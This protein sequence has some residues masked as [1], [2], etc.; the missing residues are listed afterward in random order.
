MFSRRIGH[1]RL[2]LAL[3]PLMIT[4]ALVIPATPLVWAQTSPSPC[5][6]VDQI[7][8][9]HGSVS[10]SHSDAKSWNGKSSD[11]YTIDEWEAADSTSVSGSGAVTQDRQYGYL[12]NGYMNGANTGAYA[13]SHK[14][15][16]TYPGYPPIIAYPS[17]Q[18]WTAQGGSSRVFTQIYVFAS[19]CTAQ[20]IIGANIEGTYDSGGQ[21]FASAEANL[22]K[23]PI[24]RVGNRF[25]I[26]GVA[27]AL[28]I[29]SGS[30]PIGEIPPHDH[31]VRGVADYVGMYYQRE[32]RTR[33]TARVPITYSFHSDTFGPAPGQLSIE[34]LKLEHGDYPSGNWITV[35][36]TGTYDGNI[37]RATIRLRNPGDQPVEAILDV[38]ETVANVRI[39]TCP[40][41]ITVPPTGNG[42]LREIS[43]IWDTQGF[44]WSDGA[45]PQASSNRVIRATLT[46][47]GG[48]V[49]TREAPVIVNPRPVFLFHNVN[50]NAQ[51][52][53]SYRGFMQ[54]RHQRWPLFTI[55]EMAT[56][57]SWNNPAQT[58]S[59]QQN[60]QIAN[61][62]IERRR[63]DLDAWHFD[64]LGHG[65]GGLVA[66]YYLH[67][68]APA[69]PERP[70]VRNLIM[71]GAPNQGTECALPHVLIDLDQGSINQAMLE[72]T[73]LLMR[74]F[75]A[76]VNNTK[77]AQLSVLLGDGPP[78]D[79]L[80]ADD[81]EFNPAPLVGSDGWVDSVSAAGSF[82]DVS[83]DTE[84]RHFRMLENQ[85]PFLNA[86]FPRL[87]EQR[88]ISAQ[89]ELSG[90]NAALAPA[91]ANRAAY[92][93]I[94][95]FKTSVAA[96]ATVELPIAMPA[97]TRAGVLVVAPASIRAELINPAGAVAAHGD[98]APQRV[99]SIANPAAGGWKL[100]L[101]STSR[102]N[103]QVRALVGV[104]GAD[105]TA[106]AHGVT[107]NNQTT[108]TI[109]LRDNNT[110]VTQATVTALIEGRAEPVTLADDGQSGDD[111]ANDGVYGAR[112]EG[113]PRFVLVQ[114]TSAAGTRLAP[115]VIA[116]AVTHTIHMPL[117]MR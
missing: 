35:P 106:S 64:L 26:S 79:C 31:R 54:A 1:P 112:V 84:L 2:I 6:G 90:I 73:P 34:E 4:L 45:T 13:Y 102:E 70:Y 114:A 66:R 51:S 48:T 16:T 104:Q 50:N 85:M 77:G 38:A 46:P 40:T 14:R 75:N 32:L 80:P 103:I 19:T 108:I 28:S 5:A 71:L 44:A 27:E 25:E 59:I 10:F 88:P 67:H 92:Q 117:V 37:V 81:G 41:T 86:I 12:Y 111:T 105:L 94:D 65:Y 62:A 97:A 23:L 57:A 78:L 18:P 93:Y 53:N 52:W 7:K 91:S 43:C 56:G 63:T 110:P 8:N 30:Y 107:S 100:R 17:G 20:I 60:A 42:P 113:A 58:F 69:N 36:T 24:I 33:V 115:V 95:R 89:S 82:G 99:L 39:A 29:W 76:T 96:G 21:F 74:A 49:T 116:P 101:I 15:T 11:G 3:F 55:D 83:R 47:I 61:A 22:N 98:A 72:Q 109:N 9:W 87:A 68:Y